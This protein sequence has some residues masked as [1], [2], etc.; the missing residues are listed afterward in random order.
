MRWGYTRAP[1]VTPAAIEG[2]EPVRAYPVIPP[3]AVRQARMK[4][5]VEGAS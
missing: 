5:W 2:M 3:P 4:A 1:T